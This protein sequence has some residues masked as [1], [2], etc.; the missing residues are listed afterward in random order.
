MGAKDAYNS[1]EDKWYTV[2]DSIDSKIP[3]KGTVEAV[4]SVV[5]SMLVFILVVI[6]IIAFFAFFFLSSQQVYDAKFTLT[7]PDNKPVNDT[8]IKANLIENGSVIEELSGRTDS[9]GEITFSQIKSGQQIAFDINLSREIFKKTYDISGTLDERIQLSAP[10]LV[11]APAVKQI[12]VKTPEGTLTRETIELTFSCKDSAKVPV[13]EKASFTAPTPIEI[14]EPVNCALM[15]TVNNSKYKQKTY[16]VNKLVYDLYLEGFEPTAAKL[17]VNIRSGGLPVSGTNFKVKI[18]GDTSFETDSGSSSQA[19]VDLAEGIYLIA[20][21]DPKNNYGLVTQ[22]VTV[23]GTSEVVMEVSKSVKS[24]TTL[25]VIDSSTNAPIENAIVN[26]RDSFGREIASSNTDSNGSV[27]FSFF[28]LGE[29]TFFAKKISDLNES[30][31]TGS[32]TQTLSANTSLTIPLDKITNLNAGK[33]TVKVTDQDKLPVAN[34]RVVL[35]Y[36]DNDGLVELLQE[37]NYAMTDINGEVTFIAGQITGKV[38]AYTAKGPFNGQSKEKLISLDQV[39]LFDVTLEVG[40]ATIKINLTGSTGDKLNGT[41]EL[42]LIEGQRT[43]TS[44]K[45]LCRKTSK[46]RT[47]SLCADKG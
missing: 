37:K 38:Y 16:E 19:T 42:L 36:M 43:N 9:G 24:R 5:P 2:I 10:A 31:F 12:F 39:N 11:L 17:I 45:W 14:T 1:L 27:T 30:Y 46:S 20:V 3:I 44:R 18:S 34:A 35:K 22:T 25:S 33:T 6:L 32:T 47:I 23:S 8:L 13:P 21:S 15:A 40:T 26:V 4:D 41:A 29:Y 28:D 7:T